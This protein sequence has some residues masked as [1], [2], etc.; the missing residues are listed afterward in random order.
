MFVHAAE[1]CI[2]WCS[3]DTQTAVIVRCSADLLCVVWCAAGLVSCYATFF[4]ASVCCYV[5]VDVLFFAEL[6]FH[7]LTPHSKHVST[8]LSACHRKV[9]VLE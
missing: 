7:C 3:M 5:I 2:Q 8:Y 9:P 4:V 1:G 6:P